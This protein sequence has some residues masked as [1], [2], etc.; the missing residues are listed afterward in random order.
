MMGESV[1]EWPLCLRILLSPFL[2]LWF[3][4]RV[5]M[6]PCIGVAMQRMLR[7]CCRGIL[8][9]LCCGCGLTFTDS[10]FPATDQSI[11]KE[12]IRKFNAAGGGVEW[13][14][15]DLLKPPDDS[16][17]FHLFN[18]GVKADDVKQGALGDCWLVAAMA[19][20]AGTMPGAIKK[21]FANSERSFRQ[22]LM[23]RVRLFDITQDRWRTIT[24]DDNI[25]TRNGNPIF[26]KPNGKELWVVL[27]EKAVAKF[28]GSYSN[29]AGGFEA[30]GLRVLTGNH[31]WTF[32]RLKPVREGKP[33]QWRRYEFLFKP[34]ANNKRD[35]SSIG[36][37]EVYESDKFWGV[38][39]TY[40]QGHKGAMCCSIAGDV[41]EKV[42]KDGLIEN[43]AYSIMRAIDVHGEK[44]VQIRNPW[45]K[46]G[47]WRGRWADGTSQ[48]KTSPLINMAVGHENN[49]NDGLFWMS[50]EDFRQVWMEITVC[51]RSTDA[52]DLALDVHEDLGCPG[53]CVGCLGGCFGYWCLCRGCKHVICPTKSK[54]ATRKGRKCTGCLCCV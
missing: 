8:R 10:S 31:V 34:S 13:K 11:G 12:L 5:Y 54:E 40:A 51:S 18:K 45:G 41:M 17:P 35:A 16:E 19:T 1:A 4:A 29:I 25:P 48:W 3:G 37:E 39:L 38:L 52:S 47:E 22:G 7:C 27:L 21:L 42:R 50:W 36:T 44:L 46:K 6:L 15:A 24:V 53:P 49:D 9:H 20:L 23:Y 43:H 28:C 32:R 30:W 14:R 26:A 33:G 2:L